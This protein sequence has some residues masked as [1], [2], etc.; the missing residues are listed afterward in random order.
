MN[1]D[2]FKYLANSAIAKVT[3]LLKSQS[4]RGQILEPLASLYRLSL[5][6]F[7]DIGVKIG[8]HENKI[9]IND[10]GYIQGVSRWSSGDDRNN[11][12]NLF[13]PINRLLHYDYKNLFENK[14][15]YKYLIS[16]A[17][18]GIDKLKN[19]YANSNTIIHS[20]DLYK[21]IL[22]DVLDDKLKLDKNPMNSSVENLPIENHLYESFTKLWKPVNLC[23]LNSLLREMNGLNDKIKTDN[24]KL[25]IDLKKQMFEHY[26]QAYNSVLCVIDINVTNIVTKIGSGM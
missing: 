24:T 20:L 3:N 9:C 11:L 19:T 4:E 2:I 5:L 16:N 10:I 17:I 25:N 21:G 26:V 23:V 12:H 18:I 14:D 22:L 13:N 6:N 15:D 8:I 1:I 7:Y